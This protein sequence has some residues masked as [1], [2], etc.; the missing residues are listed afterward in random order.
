MADKLRVIVWFNPA[1]AR[2]TYL[3]P[4]WPHDAPYSKKCVTTWRCAVFTFLPGGSAP[5]CVVLKTAYW[6]IFTL[7]NQSKHNWPMTRSMGFKPC[8]LQTE[9]C[10][11][12]F[13]M[14]CL[15]LSST[16]HKHRVLA[17]EE[18]A[19]CGGG[20]GGRGGVGLRLRPW[21][22][23]RNQR[24]NVVCCP[25]DHLFIDLFVWLI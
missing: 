3:W 20:G 4:S 23:Y 1:V 16:G 7:Q 8:L 12:V 24:M 18:K 15:N 21:F 5:W 13:E 6:F 19:W 14:A 10:Y 25:Q 11:W 9:V 22:N 17:F 2:L